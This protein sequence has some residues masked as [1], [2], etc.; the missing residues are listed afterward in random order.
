MRRTQAFAVICSVLV[1]AMAFAPAMVMD[2]ED[3]SEALGTLGSFGIGF[4]VGLI[5]GG[6]FTHFVID[7]PSD[8]PD[9][10][11]MMDELKKAFADAERGKVSLAL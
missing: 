6:L 3:D 9:Y 7:A 5:V 8:G 4:F 11:A 2:E 1:L 10:A